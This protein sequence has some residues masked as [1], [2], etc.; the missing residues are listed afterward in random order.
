MVQTTSTRIRKAVAPIVFAVVALGAT[1]PIAGAVDQ[2][3][4]PPAEPENQSVRE[5]PPRRSWPHPIALGLGSL[6]LLGAA[7]TMYYRG[8]TTSGTQPTAT[9]PTVTYAAHWDIGA[10]QI[11]ADV[12]LS[13]GAPLCLVPG[14]KAV[15]TTLET[16]DL[17]GAG[18]ATGG[19]ADEHR[20]HRYADAR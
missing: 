18:H 5:A 3:P 7:G 4:R 19:I 15:T 12:P 2:F 9:P 17:V 13:N 20:E 14:V 16:D 6:A 8:R 10:P 11:G 1:V